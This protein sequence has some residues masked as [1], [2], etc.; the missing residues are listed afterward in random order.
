MLQKKTAG[1]RKIER[2]DRVLSYFKPEKKIL[3]LIA[4]GGIGF[5]GGMIAGPYFEGRLAQ[6][7]YECIQGQATGKDMLRL[8]GVYLSVIFFVQLM[9]SLKRF[10]GARLRNDLGRNMRH[11]LYNGIVHMSR[12]EV[13]REN[14]GAM[15]TKAVADVDASAQGM[16]QVTTEIF[17]TGVLLGSYLGMLLVYDWRLTL[18]ACLF[19]PV[20]YVIALCLKGP[21]TRINERFKQTAGRLNQETLDRVNNAITY[22]VYGREQDRDRSYEKILTEYEKNA[23]AS[24]LWGSATTPIY[25]TIAMSGILFI[26]WFGGKS[27][28]GTGWTVWDI[29]MFTTFVSCF[30]KFAQKVSS[31]ARM[32]NN[33]QRA[34]VSWRRIKPLFREYV[35]LPRPDQEAFVEKI[36]V[37]NVAVSYP[38]CEPVLRGISFEA[39][40]GQVIGITGA[41]AC[42]KTALAKTFIGD[43]VYEGSIRLD[44]RQLRDLSDVE[45][46]GLIAYMGHEPELMSDSVRENI[47]LGE[48]AD[49]A[50]L[51][52]MVH[53]D[54]EVRLMPDGE[55]TYVGSGGQQLSGG[56]QAR[57]ALARTLCHSRSVMILDDPFSAVDQRTER[58]IFEELRR[59]AE[60]RIVLL[61]SHRLALFSETDGVLYLHDGTGTFGT[62]EELL[63][64]NAEYASLYRIQQRSVR[65]RRCVYEQ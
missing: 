19:I 51:L 20:A 39:A 45:K 40:K 23:V 57:I 6:C 53:M 54:E 5:N 43:A 1:I 50:A 30:T 18:L 9:R 46:S 49:T 17:D 37:E 26:I 33:M 2:P 12:E 35:E 41:V 32:F 4:I 15:M 28:L 44:G 48:Q 38:G 24:N 60:H 14:T 34:L 62:H 47:L 31:S 13:E 11:M 42:G 63:E 64:E 16:Q 29:G 7:L 56:Q 27:V 8:A 58:E 22:R 55:D 21:V 3:L 10:S 61:L 36:H 65:D 25:N 52:K 59:L